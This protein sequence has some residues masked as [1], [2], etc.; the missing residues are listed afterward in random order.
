MRENQSYSALTYQTGTY[1]SQAFGQERE[2][3]FV[4]PDWDG[5]LTD[6][7]PRLPLLV[8]LHGMDC[9]RRSWWDRTRIRRWLVPYALATV[10][11][12]GGNGWYTNAFD[13]SADFERDFI[14]DFLPHLEA[15]LPIAPFDK[16]NRGIGG[17]SMGGYGAV[18]LALKHPDKFSLAFSHSGSLE[19][20]R[21]GEPHPVFGHPDQDRSCRVQEDVF[22]WAERASCNWYTDRPFL[23]LDCGQDDPH[24]DASRRFRNHLVFLGY[25]HF[26]RELPGYHTWPYWDRAFKTL[27]PDIASRIGA[28]VRT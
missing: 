2:F 6:D 7:T 4:I 27:L 10:F 17:M 22:R 21:I 16:R 5:N 1:F 3:G 23:M 8:L 24:L 20:P 14:E 25:P 12:D 19:K 18:K 26:Y 9:D 13:G 15:T 28:M 11:Y